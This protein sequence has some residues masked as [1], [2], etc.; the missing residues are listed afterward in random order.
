MASFI[1]LVNQVGRQKQPELQKN[2]I[3][4]VRKI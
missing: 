3:K 4:K 2:E 1:T